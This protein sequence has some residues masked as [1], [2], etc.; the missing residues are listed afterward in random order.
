MTNEP[1]AA[2]QATQVVELSTLKLRVGLALQAQHLIEGGTLEELQFLAVIGQKGIMVGP[3]RSGEPIALRVGSEYLIRGFTGQY[4]FHFKATVM[5]TFDKPF[6]YALLDYPATVNA[7]LVRRAM[8]IKTSIPARVMSKDKRQSQDVTLVDLSP[9][10]TLIHSPAAVGAFGDVVH[11]A[12]KVPF[13]G[14]LVELEVPSTICHSYRCDRDDGIN[15]GLAF[16]PS[17]RD[18]K[19]MLHF[20]A[21]SAT[22]DA[23]A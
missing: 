2:S 22:G 11:L 7:R 1:S 17:T 23:S 16:K 5:Q 13:D 4:D 14:E 18:D 19:L 9:L 21:E 20:L 6:A 3:F 15:V 10:G 12:L 8:R